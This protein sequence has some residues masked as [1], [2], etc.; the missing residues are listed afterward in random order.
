MENP[1]GAQRDFHT[2][3]KH[4]LTIKIYRAKMCSILQLGGEVMSD[5]GLHADDLGYLIKQ[6]SDKMRANAV[7]RKHGLTY[8]QVHVLSFV[9]AC[10]GSATQKEIE[11]Y[12]DVSHPTIVGLVSRLEKS[13]FVTSHVDENNRRNKIVCVT[14]KAQ[15]TRESLEIERQKTERRLEQA[16]GQQERE[17]LMHLL[18]R[19][20]QIL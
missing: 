18:S 13:G 6:I 8:S 4:L 14:K 3:A 17:Q 10:G 11:I 12:L 2:H 20:S 9:Q 15:Q 1:A 19:L 5:C 16:L 7:F